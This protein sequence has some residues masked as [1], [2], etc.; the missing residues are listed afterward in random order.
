MKTVVI[1]GGT[2]GIGEALAYTYL[3]RGDNV[4]VIGPS[5]DKGEK[6]LTR[7][8]GL[9]AGPRSFFIRA[10]LSLVAEN[11]QVVAEIREK[12]PVVDALVLCARFFRSYRRVTDEGFEHN[13]A[14]YYLSRFLLGYGLADLLEKA[15]R[16]V[17]MNVAGPG[18]EAGRIHWDDLGLERG[19][20]GWDAMFQG[21]KLNDLLGVSFAAGH[22]GYR[23]RYVLD[24]PGG[25]AT[26]FAGEFDPATAAHIRAMLRS[27]KPVE[28]GIAPIVAAIDS[29]PAEPLSAFFEGRRLD[30]RRHR[31]FDEADAARLDAVTRKL[32]AR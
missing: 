16:P 21:G 32:L 23:T 29:P 17:I 19:Y 8:D 20:D 28:A 31:S 12:F 11:E 15:P 3:K 5:P 6:F 2:S 13:F 9:G 1:S 26:G 10:D 27:A 4:V 25:T 18:I 22:R 24:F 14:L 7:A 30:L